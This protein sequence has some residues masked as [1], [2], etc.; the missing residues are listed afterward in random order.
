MLRRLTFGVAVD[1]GGG[2]RVV[3][4]WQGAGIRRLYGVLRANI[5]TL[6]HLVM[7]SWPAE[8]PGVQY[9]VQGGRSWYSTQ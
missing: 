7:Y 4:L 3:V 6:L 2:G 1:G 5:T 9:A 8:T